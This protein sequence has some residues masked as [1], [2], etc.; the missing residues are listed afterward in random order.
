MKEEKKSLSEIL[1][2]N[3]GYKMLALGLAVLTFIVINL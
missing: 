2:S 3:F 1:F